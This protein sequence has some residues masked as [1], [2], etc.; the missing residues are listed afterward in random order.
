MRTTL[1]ILFASVM[2]LAQPAAN[3]ALA[4]VKPVTRE[5]SAGA[6]KYRATTGMLPLK[7]DAGV[8]EANLFYVAYT[9]LPETAGRPLTFC[10]NG[11]PGAGSLWLHVGAIGP[12]RVKMNDDGSMPPAPYALVDNS[13]TWLEQSDLVF[14][15]PVGTGYS[16]ARDAETAKKFFGLKGDTESVGQFIRL[17]LGMAQRWTSP[18]YVAGE[19]YGTTRAS[20]LTQWLVDHGI[21]LNGTML[22]STIMNFQTA[23]FARG[24]D[25][26]YALFLPTYTAMLG[27]REILVRRG[28]AEAFWHD[29]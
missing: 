19:S 13:A 7:N 20:S 2:A 26:P 23:R 22:I 16:R 21:A 3:R 8:I 14:I 5:L 15:D 10:F 6:L 29:S 12:K 27:L 24:N 11:G 9:K 17:Y 4:E 18:L 28:A 1:V 25:L